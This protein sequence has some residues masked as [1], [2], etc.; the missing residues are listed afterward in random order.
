MK[1]NREEQF[2]KAK[3]YAKN[4]N[5][6][7]LSKLDD[8]KKFNSILLWKCENSNHKEWNSKYNSVVTLNSWCPE[9]TNERLNAK[10][11][12]QNGLELAQELAKI[13]NGKCLSTEYVNNRT[14]MLWKCSNAN[15]KEWMAPYSKIKN[16]CWCPECAGILSPEEYLEKAKNKALSNKGEC[17]SN[18]YENAHHKLIWKCNNNEHDIWE[19]TYANVVNHN[20]WCPECAGYLSPEK[21]IKNAKNYAIK[22]GGIC[23]SNECLDKSS[24]LLWKCGNENHKEWTARY[25]IVQ[26]G[27]W[28]V[29]CSNEKNSREQ[30]LSNGL[31]LAKKLAHDKNGKCLSTIYLG[32][33]SKLLWK[34]AN[35]EHKPWEALFGNIQLGKWCPECY[36]LLSPEKYLEKAY[37]KA[38]DNGGKCLSTEYINNQTK[39]KWKCNINNHKIWEASYANIVNHNKWCPECA[40]LFHYKENKIRN[41]LNYLLNTTFI[42]IKPKWNINPKTNKLLELDGYSEELNLAFEFQGRQ[43]FEL[44]F[45]NNEED[46]KY[47][48]YKDNIKKDNCKK[49]N[50]KLLIINHTKECDNNNKI[51]PYLLSLLYSENINVRNDIDNTYIETIL[52]DMSTYQEQALKKAQDYAK[53]R[54][55]K[56]LSLNYVNK[57]DK[58]EWKCA[59]DDHP[60]W[61]RAMSLV[62]SKNW[63]RKC[64]NLLK[65]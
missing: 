30:I 4:K 10:Y 33:K 44:A 37:K 46:L 12:L 60:S 7:C 3:E 1:T 53:S 35:I 21:L 29:E 28:C 58:L 23:L 25:K 59:N 41:L 15:H 61:F 16:G 24:I 64:R 9:C 6:K 31:E 55:G 18:V 26:R 36:G 52:N 54:G 38:S 50:I 47:I 2:E 48:Q 13:K 51:L 5:G 65:K 40:K 62:Y 39:M 45:N 11:K 20:R 43:H 63:C 19:A 32:Q 22:K 27:N 57:E 17:L 49:Q 14:K 56:C 34:C 42:S 8:Y